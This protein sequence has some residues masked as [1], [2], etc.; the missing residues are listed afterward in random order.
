MFL[1]ASR[2][3][4]F[5]PGHWPSRASRSQVTGYCRQV[6]NVKAVAGS[7]SLTKAVAEY[8]KFSGSTFS[9]DREDPYNGER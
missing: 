2:L 9:C 3:P 4:S 5:A 8:N 7:Q 1:C 6:L